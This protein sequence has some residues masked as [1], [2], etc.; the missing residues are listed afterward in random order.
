MATKPTASGALNF[1][2]G[3][4]VEPFVDVTPGFKPNSL[5]QVGAFNQPRGKFFTPASAMVQESTSQK[6]VEPFFTSLSK[7]GTTQ[8]KP[9]H[10]A[11]VSTAQL[12]SKTKTSTPELYKGSSFGERAGS[13]AKGALSYTNIPELA[14]GIKTGD[15]KPYI[16]KLSAQA[17][18]L[19]EDPEELA[20]S[21]GP[22]AAGTIGRKVFDPKRYVAEQVA[23]AEE[24]AGK[25]GL[26]QRVGDFWR[27]F[28]VK[29]VDSTAPIEDTLNQYAR[30]T[31][32]KIPETQ[33]VMNQVDRVYRAP[34][35]AG[36]FVKD[37]GLEAV[38]REVDNIDELDQ[39][40]IARQAKD[41]NAKGITTGRDLAAD[42]QLIDAFK[43]KYGP[44][45]QRVTKYSH[46]LLDY[47]VDSGL[48]SPTLA[49]HLKTLYPNYVPMQR[50]FSEL[51][52]GADA[53]GGGGPASLTSQTVVRKLEGSERAV[54][55]PLKSLLEK[56]LDAFNQGEKN[57]AGRLLASYRDLPGNPFKL[58]EKTAANSSPHTISFL[59]HGEKRIFVTTKEVAEAAKSLNVQ[60][61][62][63]LGQ[64][65]AMPVRIA[66]LGITGVNIP[67]VLSNI[68]KDQVTAFINSNNALRGSVANPKVFLQ[69]LF[70]A[71]GHNKLYQEVV[72]AGGAGTSF[73]MSRNQLF[74]TIQSIRSGRSVPSKILYTVTHPGSL[75]RAVE[76]IVSRSEEFTRIQQYTAAKGA[77]LGK[78]VSEEEAIAQGAKAARENTVNFMRRGEWGTV[79]NSVFLYLNAGIQGSRTFLWNLKTKPVETSAKVAM[80]TF[81]PM[82]L[83]TLWNLND[84]KRKEAYADIAEYEKENNFIVIPPNPTKDE[85]GKWNVIKI[86]LSQEIAHL[87]NMPRRIMEQASGLDPVRATEIF[88]ALAGSV[89]P[90]KP[91]ARSALSTLVPQAVKP[92]VESFTNQN[93]FT[94]LPIVPRSQ[95]SLPPELQVKDYTSGTARKVGGLTGT[96]PL[97]VENFIRS[98]FG[99]VGSQVI[100]ASD[101]I[102]AAGGVIPEE[103][104]GGESIVEG[105]TRRFGKATGG[106][107]QRKAIEH[108]RE[109]IQTQ[110]AEIARLSAEAEKKHSDFKAL[111]KGEA[112]RAFDALADENPRLAKKVADVA[113]QE[114]IGLTPTDRFLMQLDVANGARAKYIFQTLETMDSEKEKK[115]YYDDLLKK[116]VISKSVAAQINTLRKKATSE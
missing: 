58:E 95:E 72:R 91:D 10:L 114:S 29:M 51:E 111:P 36:Q 7:G 73:D 47:A 44:Y 27:N 41:L 61:L 85:N 19:A 20:L 17:K 46:D 63:I 74:D 86:P 18:R 23:R 90:I 109:A 93:L 113:Y 98:S 62:N 77:A 67:F 34:T 59:D 70:A 39:F 69:S 66:R 71:V 68:A 38:I 21:F 89:Q 9:A 97:K 8:A 106:E 53:F 13:L 112:R 101:K 64:I 50:V 37:T 57:K 49:G 16:A 116:K 65:F 104:V 80:T 12:S 48:V 81:T 107:V 99:G 22:G 75:L 92:T 76:N 11:P 4:S 60:T 3:V 88:Q 79:L 26:V 52:K 103:Q 56:T 102:L 105:V 42:E 110:D 32:T 6:K 100:N 87:A 108:I 78:G 96:S 31:G 55:S 45:A 54:E 15:F 82:V 28:K 40:L 83:T 2:N 43:D 94:G 25:P 30:A 14:Q 24:A 33:N 115:A 5:S 1:L 84:E 35:L